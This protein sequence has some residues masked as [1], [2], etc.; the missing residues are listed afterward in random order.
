[1]NTKFLFISTLIIFVLSAC[2]GYSPSA[3]FGLREEGYTDISVNDF[4]GMM[5]DK[6]FLLINV[7]V[8]FSGD[9]PGTDLSIPFDQIEANLDRLPA[10]KKA[11]IIVYCRSGSMSSQAADTLAG[12]GYT[13][14]LNLSGGMYAW[15]QE[16]ELNL[17]GAE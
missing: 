13:N 17:E 2:S 10:D 8:P 16:T 14:I 3:E 5:E 7:H 11:K 12:L 6:D 9:I 15:E 1:M 4:Q